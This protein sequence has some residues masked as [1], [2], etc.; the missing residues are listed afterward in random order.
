MKAIWMGPRSCDAICFAQAFDHLGVVSHKQTA[1]CFPEDADITLFGTAEAERGGRRVAWHD[2]SVED[3]LALL[4]DD[5]E[6]RAFLEDGVALRGR[7]RL[8]GARNRR[9]S[10][11]AGTTP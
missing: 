3:L 6:A 7:G 1:E 10:L 5:P 4:R 11:P 2:E 8:R 9:H